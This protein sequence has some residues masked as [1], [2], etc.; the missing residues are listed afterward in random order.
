LVLDGPIEI[1]GEQVATGTALLAEP[2]E[3][4]VLSG[5][6]RAVLVGAGG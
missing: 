4:P 6:G 1:A 3:H 5:S 2:A